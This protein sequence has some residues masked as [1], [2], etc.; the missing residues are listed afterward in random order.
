MAE[1]VPLRWKI[2]EARE[3]AREAHVENREDDQG[4][5]HASRDDVSNAMSAQGVDPAHARER[6][7]DN[8]SGREG[9]MEREVQVDEQERYRQKAEAEAQPGPGEPDPR[10]RQRAQADGGKVDRQREFQDHTSVRIT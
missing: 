10:Q 1:L 5:P 8:A 6:S 9:Y 2:T 3:A 4:M 7:Y